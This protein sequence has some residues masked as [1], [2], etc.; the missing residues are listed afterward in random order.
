MKQIKKIEHKIV[1][2][3]SAAIAAEEARKKNAKVVFT[4]GCFDIL[5]P[6]HL[7]ILAAAKDLGD[8]LIVGL[9]SDSSV[10]LLKGPDRPV[11]DESSRAMLLAGLQVVDLVV[12]FSEETP[13]KLIETI[14]PDILVKG[15]DY[16]I[17]QIVGSAHVKASGGQV[18]TI[19]LLEGF[20]TTGIISKSK[21]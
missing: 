1:T 20:S 16:K 13:L 3:E 2:W 19:P 14:N 8:L 12:I 5:H 7:H 9:N 17:D 18:I 10:K 21:Q 11:M 4:N 6:G 15:G